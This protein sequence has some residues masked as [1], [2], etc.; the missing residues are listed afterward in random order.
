M[1]TEESEIYPHNTYSKIHSEAEQL[2]NNY[3]KY[4]SNSVS[5]RLTNG[6]GS[7]VNKDVNCWTLLVND[8]C[9]QAIENKRI[10]LKAPRLTS[11]DFIPISSFLETVNWFLENDSLVKEYNILNISSGK[12]QSLKSIT[13]LID[14]R[15]K[16][17]FGQSL[18]VIY[19]NSDVN[20]ETNNYVFSNQRALDLG[21]KYDSS[22]DFEIDNLLI[23][24]SNWFANDE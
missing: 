7:P 14:K 8:L 4:F 22:L 1:I 12:S 16:L 11:R 20:E 13:E 24:C 15:Y 23:N 21:V 3:A 5:F 18:E 2:L 9:R 19:E 6:V 10:R 17:L